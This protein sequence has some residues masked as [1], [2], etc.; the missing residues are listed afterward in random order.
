MGGFGRGIGVEIL[1][2]RDRW[3]WT[4]GEDGDFNVK[5]LTSLIKEKILLVEND[6]H[7]TRLNKLVSKKVNV[8][9]WRAIKGR[10]PVHVELE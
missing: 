2:V 3:R 10:L 5:I 9:V 1:T 7:D 6:G 8:F 4:L